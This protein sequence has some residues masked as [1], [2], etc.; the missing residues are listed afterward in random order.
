MPLV[1]RSSKKM[2]MIVF[3]LLLLSDVPRETSYREKIIFSPVARTSCAN[4]R[5]RSRNNAHLHRLKRISP[6]IICAEG[7]RKYDHSRSF[8]IVDTGELSSW[9]SLS[10]PRSTVHVIATEL[11]A[12]GSSVIHLDIQSSTRIQREEL[13]D[14]NP[15]IPN[16]MKFI[17]AK[18]ER[19]LFCQRS[20]WNTNSRIERFLPH[21]ISV[22]DSSTGFWTGWRY[23]EQMN[24]RHNSPIRRWDAI[25]F[26]IDTKGRHQRSTPKFDTKGRRQ[27]RHEN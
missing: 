12:C 25:E 14:K 5:S 4:A 24:D 11:A 10:S 3:F 18:V 16:T 20:L 19:D 27:N 21:K 17:V 22:T 7:N 9:S 13:P 6:C 15:T 26:Q 23:N 1:E 8:V 2:A